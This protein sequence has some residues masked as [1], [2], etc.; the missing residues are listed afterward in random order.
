MDELNKTKMKSYMQLYVAHYWDGMG[1]YIGIGRRV[2]YH[3]VGWHR[4]V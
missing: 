2:G 4:G 1:S 3:K